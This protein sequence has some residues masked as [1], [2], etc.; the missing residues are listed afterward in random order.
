MFEEPL[1]LFFICAAVFFAGLVDSIAGGGGLI[2]LPAYLFVGIPPHIAYGCNKFASSCGTTLATLRFLKNG[3]LDLKISLIAAAQ[4]I[5]W[6]SHR[7]PNC[8]SS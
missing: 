2:S 7:R 3:V 8:F 1:T 5:H 6:F 4:F